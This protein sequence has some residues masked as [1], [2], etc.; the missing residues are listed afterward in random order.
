MQ[1]LPAATAFPEPVIASA[2]DTTAA[3]RVSSAHSLF[4]A[5]AAIAVVVGLMVTVLLVRRVY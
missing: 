3:A 4:I 1:W 2:V 5:L